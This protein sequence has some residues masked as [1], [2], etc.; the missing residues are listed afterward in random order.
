MSLFHWSF[1]YQYQSYFLVGIQLLCLVLILFTGPVVAESWIW[2]GL[3][4][5]GIALGMWALGS[6]SLHTMNIFPD[7]RAG[8]I[9]VTHGPYH[10]IRHPMYTA[11][12]LISF[13]LILS[14]WSWPRVCLGIILVG[15]LI[16]KLRYEERLLAKHFKSYQAYQHRTACLF[17]YLF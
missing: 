17:P 6:M 13:A 12:L 2:G 7:V 14:E 1:P 4:L 9:L 8:S 5:F 11:V 10:Y 15:D 16:V 3:E